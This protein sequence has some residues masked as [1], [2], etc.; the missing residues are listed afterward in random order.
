M[1]IVH[2][3]V[4][5]L[6]AAALSFLPGSAAGDVADYQLT[7][8]ALEGDP[9]PAGGTIASIAGEVSIAAGRVAFWGH[10]NPSGD[11][12][13]YV[14]D[15]GVLAVAVATGDPAPD[16]GGSLLTGVSRA[17][18]ASP[19]ALA[20]SGAFAGS[21][22]GFLRSGA[23]DVA[24]ALPGSVLAGGGTLSEVPWV[25]SAAPGPWVAFGAEVDTG[26]P[27]PIAVHLAY[28][29]SGLRE[30][31]REGG[32]APAGVGGVFSPVEPF[33]EAGVA[34]DGSV[35]F[36]APVSG[37]S[38]AS[39]LFR[40]SAAGTTT[41]LL[42]EGDAVATAG[43]GTFTGFGLWAGV[44]AAG[45]VGF[46]A[47]VLRAPVAFPREAVFA[48]EAG[49][50]REIVIRGD[51]VP[52][53]PAVA[54]LFGGLSGSSPPGLSDAGIVVFTATLEDAGLTT[55]VRAVVVEDAGDLG[56][57][58]KEGDPVP[59]VAGATFLDFTEA[60]IDADGRIAIHASTTQGSGVFLATQPAK[61]PSLSWWGLTAL[62]ALLAFRGVAATRS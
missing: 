50:Q 61:V 62:A 56:V 46:N 59:G 54:P 10:S 43:G 16:T 24:M 30:I 5:W 49:A 37:G 60:R 26:G 48:L 14:V 45:D 47:D 13:V 8:L 58:V 7:T 32:A 12:R 31:Y 27:D 44:N 1:R 6:A 35:T 20:Y 15:G 53:A 42:L 21:R 4:G 11:E 29:P 23:A 28:G 33:H 57:L 22:G 39:G 3:R 34:A 38:A 55:S 40:S 51:P 52:G 36:G 41:S 19:D 18:V 9:D 2:T 25:H 17:R